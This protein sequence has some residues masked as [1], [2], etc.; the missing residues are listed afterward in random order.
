MEDLKKTLTSK[1]LID[2]EDK[3]GAHNYHPLPVVLARGEGAFMWDVEGKQYYDF[4]GGIAVNALGYSHP[5]L[6]QAMKNQAEKL[7]HCSNLYYS[8]PQIILAQML[9]EL[10]FGEK[11]FFGNSG[12]EVK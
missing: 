2:L 1:H 12:A 4:I 7:I 6:I 8:E 10:S 5:R 11:V 9:I 3:Y